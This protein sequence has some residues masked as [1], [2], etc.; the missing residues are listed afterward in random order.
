[1]CVR[2]DTIFKISQELQRIF[3]IA[4]TI[5]YKKSGTFNETLIEACWHVVFS[6]KRAG[7]CLV[8]DLKFKN[9]WRHCLLLLL[10][11]KANKNSEAARLIT[12]L[13]NISS[14]T[15][16]FEIFCFK[17]LEQLFFRT[18]FSSCFLKLYYS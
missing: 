8:I 13:Q 14:I 4:G 16:I 10:C 2:V 18:H 17:S 12:R 11:Q 1:M 15:G 5:F 3:E 6:Q 9:V 7:F